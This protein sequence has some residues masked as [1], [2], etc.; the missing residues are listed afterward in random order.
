MRD[1]SVTAREVE[2]VR[3]APVRLR[4]GYRMSEVDEHLA[5]LVTDLTVIAAA[6]Y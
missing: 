6:G 4:T 3:F 5:R 2:E 1:G